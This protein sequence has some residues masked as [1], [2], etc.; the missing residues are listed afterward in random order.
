MSQPSPSPW[1][2]AGGWLPE[3]ISAPHNQPWMWPSKPLAYHPRDRSAFHPGS[4]PAPFQNR[5]FLPRAADL[6]DHSRARNPAWE[7]NVPR[8]SVDSHIDD[9]ISWLNRQPVGSEGHIPSPSNVINLPKD[10]LGTPHDWWGELNNQLGPPR[11]M[12]PPPRGTTVDMRPP[13]QEANMSW[14]DREPA[15]SAAL[16]DEI[17]W[18]NRQGGSLTWN[19]SP[20]P[21]WPSESL[22]REVTDV[23]PYPPDIAQRIEQM[24]LDAQFERSVRELQ[25]DIRES[26]E[27]E[28]YRALPQ[29][30]S[31]GPRGTTGVFPSTPPAGSNIPDIRGPLAAMALSQLRGDTPAEATGLQLPPP[32][33]PG[34][35]FE[36]LEPGAWMSDSNFPLT[37]HQRL[38]MDHESALF[39]KERREALASRPWLWDMRNDQF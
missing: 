25:R 39:S 11:G 27:R 5:N 1:K 29:G 15:L 7:G 16:D 36:N 37:P 33:P 14:L 38:M 24:G 9:E 31:A 35:G 13:A 12:T 23:S 21:R 8:R 2:S 20:Q 18:L 28:L 22:S 3:E 32:P 4:V 26:A 19:G 34:P 30:Y 17:S 10:R 6:S